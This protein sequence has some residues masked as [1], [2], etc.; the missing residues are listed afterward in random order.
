MSTDDM[1]RLDS[2]VPFPYC[3]QSRT[4]TCRGAPVHGKTLARYGALP[5][6]ALAVAFGALVPSASSS[7]SGPDVRHSQNL[8]PIE[9]AYSPTAPYTG[10]NT[11]AVANHLG[12]WQK[13]GL[14]LV[15]EPF[16]VAPVVEVAALE[17]N[18]VNVMFGGPGS[19]HLAMVG[20][21]RI[22]GAADFSEEDFLV[23]NSS[24]HKISTLK[25][26]SVIFNQGTTG[27]II[28]ALALQ[29]V[30]LNLTDI[31]GIDISS[32]GGLISAFVS[33][34]APAVGTYTPIST[35]VLQEVPH[36]HVLFTD[37]SG[38]PKLAM[39]DPI[40]TSVAY[41]KSNA[42]TL[43]RF[44]WVYDKAQEWSLAHTKASIELSSAYTKV[45]LATVE[46]G[47][48]PGHDKI[49][50]PTV[51]DNEYT[52]DVGSTWFVPLA[53]VFEEMKVITASS[54]VP[55]GQYLDYGPAL[56]AAKHLSASTF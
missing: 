51:L 2:R 39:P 18:H 55:R 11:V 26:K 4:I 28:L 50:S 14:K 6:A 53:K 23:A 24:I 19:V 48:P 36:S 45:A 43:A 49:V 9:V 40:L 33:G 34:D 41:A 8:I 22:L 52:H 17:S 21:A 12:L 56:A 13:A 5:I 10:V 20:E 38:F 31:H 27:E 25:G 15:P 35:K 47:A 3:M 30:G 1:T 37:K 54:L 7:A 16:T 42:G 44:M 46:A 29:S 32:T